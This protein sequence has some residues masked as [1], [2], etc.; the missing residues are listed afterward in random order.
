LNGPEIGVM[1][2]NYG[3]MSLKSNLTSLLKMMDASG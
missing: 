3:L 1:I 2:Q